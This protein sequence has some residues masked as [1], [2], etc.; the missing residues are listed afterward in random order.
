MKSETSGNEETEEHCQRRDR[1][2]TPSRSLRSSRLRE[3]LRRTMVLTR[4]R[5]R[6]TGPG[7]A[8]SIARTGPSVVTGATATTVW[9]RAFSNDRPLQPHRPQTLQVPL[10]GLRRRQQQRLERMSL[11][12]SAI[13]TTLVPQGILVRRGLGLKEHFKQENWYGCVG[14][15]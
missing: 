11:G 5:T 3:R 1:G 15:Q 7:F 6:S 9:I 10:Q 4:R 12:T 14:V 8:V 13:T 2:A